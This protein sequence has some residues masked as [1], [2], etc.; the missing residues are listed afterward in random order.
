[1]KQHRKKVVFS[2]F[3]V[4]AN[5]VGGLQTFARE[6][7]AQ[8][9]DAGW[10]S[11]LVFSSPPTEEV[12]TLFELPNTHVESIDFSGA[13]T[14]RALRRIA[15]LLCRYRPETAH[16]HLLDPIRC[17]WLAKSL[18]VRNVFLTDHI[19]RPEGY[20]GKSSP[21]W[22]RTAKR[23]A[24]APVTKIVAV[25]DFV[26][27]CRRKED[28]FQER[29]LSRIYNGV[30]LSRACSGAG[31]RTELR[32]RYGIPDDHVIILQVSWLIPQKGVDDLIRAAQLMHKQTDRFHV[33]IAGDGPNRGEYES[34]VA[35]LGIADHVTFLGNFTDPLG[36]GLFAASDIVCQ[37][38]HWEEAFGLTIAEAMAAGKPVIGTR[39]GAIPELIVD[40][41]MG[42]TLRRGDL[43]GLADKL[44]KLAR[45]PALRESLGRAGR[46]VCQEEFSLVNNVATLIEQYGIR[47]HPSDR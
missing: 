22:K 14:I 25:S 7:S 45:D 20:C 24:Y 30:D 34:L 39:V 27:D 23:L 5:V 41:H 19:S 43:V 42:Y 44:L 47:R 16:F 1:M 15:G 18:G 26:R 6:L 11:V 4:T 31:K 28:V 36:A 17:P 2:A 13:G 38:S 37:L 8:L 35:E 40:G 46:Q 10:E 32:H 12:A 9:G 3:G 33:L 21:A 29:R